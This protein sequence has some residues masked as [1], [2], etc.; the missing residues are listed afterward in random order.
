MPPTEEREFGTARPREK[1]IWVGSLVVDCT[2]LPRMVRFWSEALHYVPA[3]P[4]APDGVFL[5]DPAG[6]GPNLNL[7]LGREGPLDD[8]RLHLDLYAWDPQGEVD[9]LI[10]LGARLVRP[11]DPQHDFVTLADPD[12]NLF[13][14][15]DIHWPDDGTPWFF[16]KRPEAE[17]S[18]VSR[19]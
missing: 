10:A 5:K 13:D 6:Q 3:R 18:D 9:R 8:Y 19:A 17:R 16:G 1:K 15:I 11:A 4:P 2:D 14:V 12:D 7:S